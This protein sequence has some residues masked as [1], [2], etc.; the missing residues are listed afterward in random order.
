MCVC[1]K[2]IVTLLGCVKLPIDDEVI[3]TD[4]S[5]YRP[6]ALNSCL[7]KTLERMSNTRL[8]LF[9]DSNGLITNFQFQYIT[10]VHFYKIM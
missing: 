7:C 4:P 3:Y 2:S 1:V 5:D 6:I 10:H 9:L 8:I